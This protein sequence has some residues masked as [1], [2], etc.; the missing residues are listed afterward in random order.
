MPYY[1]HTIT[2]S[3]I[4]HVSYVCEKCGKSSA[5]ELPIAKSKSAYNTSRFSPLGMDDHEK[6]ANDLN[7]AIQ[8]KL[9]KKE[10]GFEKCPRCLYTQSWQFRSA[11]QGTAGL[12]GIFAALAVLTIKILLLYIY[13]PHNP[14]R[15]VLDCLVPIIIAAILGSLIAA[16]VKKLYDPNKGSVNAVHTNTPTV[17]ITYGEK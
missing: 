16:V 6:L 8:Q 4:M 2:V 9:E 15:I 10:Y 7:A 14:L 1:T 3:A 11:K 5:Y 17:T 13:A 12:Y